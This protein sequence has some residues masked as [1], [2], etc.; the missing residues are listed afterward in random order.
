MKY[1]SLLLHWYQ[2]P[3]QDISLVRSIDA[4]C[5]RPVSRLLARMGVPV[6]VNINFSLTEQLQA[7]G[8]DSLENLRSAE[9][10]EFTDSGAYHPIFPLIS[11]DD[12][13]RQLDLNRQGNSA[14]L[15]AGY[16][17][18]GVFPPEM[19][20][21][22]SLAPLLSSLGYTWTVT[23]DLPWSWTGRDVPCDSVPRMGNLSILLRSNFWSNRI[24][25]HGVDG[26]ETVSEIVAGMDSWAGEGDS[27][28]LIAM[29]VETYGHHRKGMI[30][31][32]L[33]PFLDALMESEYAE[34]VVPGRL[35]ELFPPLES[36]VPAG[37][38]ST[39]EADLDQGKPW[40][41]WDD[42]DNV[43][44]TELRR[45]LSMVADASREC[46]WERVAPLAD[47]MLYSCPFWWADKG[48]FSAVQVRRGLTLILETALAVLAET[49]DRE[50]MDKIMTGACSIPVI[51]GEDMENA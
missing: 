18:T 11:S 5:Y 35:P 10:V 25:F 36:R 34:I 51:T 48:R 37:S 4:E 14:L 47:K 1:I 8:S 29:D 26:R 12:V 40:P 13:R 19:A 28:I 21:A 9:G 41:L 22:P 44:H 50:M 7:T 43:I 16:V 46:G 39:M 17:P 45:T 30:E 23:D 20:W 24:S 27:Y 38:W 6:G 15:G 3:T 49:G 33:E 2:P 42:P 32:F 31:T